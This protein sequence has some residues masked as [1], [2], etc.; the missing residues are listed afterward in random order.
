MALKH[1]S[2]ARISRAE[3]LNQK[4]NQRPGLA[5]GDGGKPVSLYVPEPFLEGYQ[6]IGKAGNGFRAMLCQ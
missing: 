1:N 2:P 6:R 4:I 3:R 5:I